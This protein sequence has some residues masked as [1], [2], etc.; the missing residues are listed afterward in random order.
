MEFSIPEKLYARSAAQILSTSGLFGNIRNYRQYTFNEASINGL[1]NNG[2][3][4]QLLA[5][6]ALNGNTPKAR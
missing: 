6:L 2:D 4:L 1:D 5:G 3:N